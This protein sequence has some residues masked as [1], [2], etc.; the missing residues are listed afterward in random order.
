MAEMIGFLRE[1]A[2]FGEKKV[3]ALLQQNLPKEYTV[4]VETPI[5]QKRELRYPDFI[6]LTNYGVIVLEVKDWVIIQ[7]A[8]PQ[9]AEVRT[10]SGETRHELNPVTVA[11]GFAIA[12]SNELNGRLLG[13]DPGETVP[14][15]YATVLINLPASTITRLRSAWGEEFVLGQADLENPDLLQDR[16]KNTFPVRHM[17]ALTRRELD[18]IRAVIY[19][20]VEF[21]QEGRP[22]VVLD[23]QQERLVAEPPRSETPAAG[24]KTPRADRA[25]AQEQLFEGPLAPEPAAAQPSET[26]PPLGERLSQ[27]VAIR[28]VRG[29]SGSG[30]TLVLI[31][32]ARFLAAQYPEW[33]IAVLTYNK[34]LQERLDA[35]FRGSSIEPR[36]FHNLLNKLVY[37]PSGQESN[38]E[39]WLAGREG[40]FPILQQLDTRSL[41]REINWLREMG[42]VRREEYLALE[43]HGIGKDSRLNTTQRAAVFDLCEHYRAYLCETGRW[44]YPELPFIALRAIESGK[45]ALERFDAVLIDEAQDWAPA[46]FCVIN[47]LVD[48]DHGLIFLADDPS[49]SIY[50]SFSWKEKGIHVVGRTRWLRVP[51]RNTYEI[52]RAAYSLIAGRDE[53]QAALADEGELVEPV[54]SCDEMRRGPAP[55]LRRF[56]GVQEEHT[57]IR[58]RALAL[59]HEGIPPNQVAVLVRYRAD[60]EPLEA[61]LRGSGVRV[62]PIHSFKGLEMEAIFLPHLQKTFHKED[63][64]TAERRLIYMAMSRARSRLYLTYAGKLP[65][66]YDPL[67]AQ[68]LADFV[69]G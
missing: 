64:E 29:F 38:L 60:V 24:Q 57:F 44:D 26:L 48:P 37:A 41:C 5:R 25:A 27:N 42:A 13:G 22:P 30:K 34:P 32:R 3:F 36:T 12:L 39:E 65:R 56:S 23:F 54:L 53:I 40:E 17:R 45:L 68:G 16:I 47:H 2:T 28:L 66:A 31:Q 18:S 63:E 10:R 7:S 1:D 6:I 43:R 62:H 35:V 15:S 52:Y 19:P 21:E 69:E 58:E 9:G 67:R 4:Y 59:T 55:L 46:W 33:K 49:Q 50:R 51:Y 61:A 14:W 8:H 11:R 20:V